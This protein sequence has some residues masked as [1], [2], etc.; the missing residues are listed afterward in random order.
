MSAGPARRFGLPVPHAGPGMPANLAVWD[1]GGDC[2]VEPPY[3]SRSTNCAFA[4]QTLR[5]VCRLTVAGGRIAHR[6]IEAVA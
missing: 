3:A 4:G 2:V 5:G 6:L 1:L